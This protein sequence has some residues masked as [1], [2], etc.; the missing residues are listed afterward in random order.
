MNIT[1]AVI[2]AAGASQR[3]L[4]LQTLVDRDGASKSALQILIEEA[5]SAGIDEICVVVHPGDES[6][7]KAASGPHASRLRFVAQDKPRGYGDAVA[8]A[9][10]FVGT[11]AFLHLVA[12][13]LSLS[14]V[15]HSCARQLA[16]IASTENCAVS[17]VQ[18]TRE[19]LLTNF[20]AIGGKR[21]AGYAGLYT[22]ENVLEKPTP[23]EAEQTLIV[24]GLRAGH[25]LCFFGIHVLTPGVM[26]LLD[27]TARSTTGSISLSTALAALATRERFLAYEV[28][29]SRYD[30]GATYGL[31]HAQLALA[32]SGKDRADVLA[33]LLEVVSNR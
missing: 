33:Q 32:L 12:D 24:P 15:E 18:A 3:N 2:T 27:H 13:H 14:R 4:P 9:R 6:A 25:Y 21:V 22:V 20:G 5:L 28:Q 23:T 11:E 19:S 17:A 7:Y 16:Q 26:D 30:L 10:Q 31:L 8:R 29:G 1:K